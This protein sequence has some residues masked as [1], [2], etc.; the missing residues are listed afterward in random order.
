MPKALQ[1]PPATDSAARSAAAARSLGARV[2]AEMEQRRSTALG[3]HARARQGQGGPR[4]AASE[5]HYAVAI[6]P[7]PWPS[8]SRKC[9]PAVFD[10]SVPRR[11]HDQRVISEA[12]GRRRTPRASPLDPLRPRQPRS[13][14]RTWWKGPGSSQG[15]FHPPVVLMKRA[16]RQEL[17]GERAARRSLPPA[18]VAP[19][20]GKDPSCAVALQPLSPFADRTAWRGQARRLSH[21]ACTSPS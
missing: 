12:P 14:I 10:S 20:G 11:G 5:S 21:T 4:S 13:S 3:E 1:A 16:A 17:F 18:T 2:G 15:Q 6:W 19:A 7:S 9:Q 8:R